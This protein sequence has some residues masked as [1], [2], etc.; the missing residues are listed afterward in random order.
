MGSAIG[1]LK[2]AAERAG[3]T[4]EEYETADKHEVVQAVCSGCHSKRHRRSR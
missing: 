2:V 3:V 4:P 1:V